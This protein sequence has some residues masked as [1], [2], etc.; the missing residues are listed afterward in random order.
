MHLRAATLDDV[1]R[2]LYP[3][4][5]EHGAP[6]V[7]SRGPN[8]ELIGMQ[9]ELEKPRARLSRT[10]TRGRPFSALGEFLWYLTRDNRLDFIRPYIPAYAEDSDDGLTV[11]GGYGPRIF[12][13]RGHD[14][15]ENVIRQ[16]R[17]SPTSRRAVIEL[18]NAEDNAKRHKEVPCT[19]T[20][21]FLLRGGELHLITTMR[22][23]DAYLGLPHDVFCFTML[24]EMAARILGAELGGY[25]HFVASMHLY[26]RNRPAAR[27]YLDEGF[28]RHVEMPPMPEGDPRPAIRRLFDAERLVRA[29]K[30][31]DADGLGL[32]PYWADLVRLLQIHFAQGDDARLDALRAEIAHPA[33]RAFVEGQRGKDPLRTLEPAQGVLTL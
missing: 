11:H 29:R 10:E 25:R 14:Q 8:S 24:Q 21:Q 13:Q 30:R 28:Q 5:M 15:F 1:L 33:Y 12:A 22:S 31:V 2:E 17:E 32:Q 18:F 4:L 3:A 23:N 7:A 20:L 16:L 27:R 9:L 26:D 19:T 6:V